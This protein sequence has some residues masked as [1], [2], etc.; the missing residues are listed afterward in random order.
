MTTV[1]GNNI[2]LTAATLAG[3]IGT[4]IVRTPTADSNDTFDTAVNLILEYFG[5]DTTEFNQSTWEI[6][7]YNDSN[8]TITL[9]AGTGTTIFPSD[10]DTILP[11]TTK[12]YI[13]VQTAPSTLEVYQQSNGNSVAVSG[14]QL[15]DGNILVG[16]STN[17]GTG[18]PLSGQ[19][20]IINTGELTLTSSFLY[21]A[22]VDPAG[23]GDYTTL[24]AAITGGA[25]RIYLKS[26]TISE[27]TNIVLPDGVRLVGE[28]KYDSIIDFG[29]NDVGLVLSGGGAGVIDTISITSGTNTVTG[30]A[31]TG[32]MVGEYI[33]LEETFYEIASVTPPTSLT[34]IKNYNG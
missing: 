33:I 27:S 21:D 16:S 29:T 22:V 26:G 13:F 3:A 2:T 4:Y 15:T 31:F 9:N 32:G 25:I 6:T 12:I 5:Q 23:G 1:G 7:I 18:V 30:T 28:S 14:I 24:S 11:Q 20:S 17:I 10:P 34:L 8:F 19:A